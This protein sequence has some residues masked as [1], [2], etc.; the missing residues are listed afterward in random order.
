MSQK[1]KIRP[2]IFL[3]AARL[4]EAE[5]KE[6]PEGGTSYYATCC[7]ALVVV[8]RNNEEYKFFKNLFSN[9]RGPSQYWFGN[10]DEFGDDMHFNIVYPKVKNQQKRIKALMKAYKMTKGKK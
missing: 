7:S 3:K 5:L 6:R 8:G 2:T 10:P 1:S 4:I 9:K